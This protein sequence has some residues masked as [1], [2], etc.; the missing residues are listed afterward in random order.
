[1]ATQIA[2]KST[3]NQTDIERQLRSAILESG[4]TLYALAKAADCDQGALG[5]FVRG[6]SGLTLSTAGR[7]AQALGLSL[8]ADT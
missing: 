5:R 7:L 1:M 3:V 4:R 6:Q 8:R 2:C